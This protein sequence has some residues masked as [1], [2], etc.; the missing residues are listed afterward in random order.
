VSREVK[1]GAEGKEGLYGRGMDIEE[2]EG[3][4]GKEG[5]N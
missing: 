2:N 3:G 1:G 4:C 5:G